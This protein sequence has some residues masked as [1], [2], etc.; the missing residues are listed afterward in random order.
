MRLPNGG[1]DRRDFGKAIG[2]GF[3]DLQQWFVFLYSSLCQELGPPAFDGTESSA[4]NT[5]NVAYQCPDL[6]LKSHEDFPQVSHFETRYRRRFKTGMMISVGALIAVDFVEN[7]N[8]TPNMIDSGNITTRH[9]L[10]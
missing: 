3:G 2:F 4:L 9:N 1:K 6:V 8:T 7:S 5:H 10:N